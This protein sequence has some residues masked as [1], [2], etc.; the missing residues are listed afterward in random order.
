MTHYFD[1][2]NFCVALFAAIKKP[3]HKY[4]KPA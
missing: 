3:G 2:P 1:T 4:R